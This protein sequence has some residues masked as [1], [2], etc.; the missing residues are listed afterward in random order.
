MV[1]GPVRP[2]FRSRP[3][4]RPNVIQAVTF[5]VDWTYGLTHN[6]GFHWPE[7]Y[8]D[9]MTIVQDIVRAGKPNS[10]RVELRSGEEPASNG[11]RCEVCLPKDINGTL[12]YENVNVTGTKYYALSTYLPSDWSP[13][14]GADPWCILVQ[15]HTPDA[16]SGASPTIALEALSAYRIQTCWGDADVGLNYAYLTLSNNALQKG[17]WVDWVLR[18]TMAKDASG[19]IYVYRRDE[20]EAQFTQVLASL[21]RTTVVWKASQ[22]TYIDH[23]WKTGIY[24][25]DFAGTNVVYLS[26]FTR[27]NT[28]KDVV[29]VHWPTG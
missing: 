11:E 2:V 14:T 4:R 12:W 3:G 21:N 9:R 10:I 25:S 8:D 6:G 18:Y 19:S 22:P 23:Y 24:R 16:I 20:G 13:P 15:L 1:A 27:G 7:I 26:G 29:D 5:N 17:H 28:F